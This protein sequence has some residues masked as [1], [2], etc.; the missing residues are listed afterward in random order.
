MSP[1]VIGNGSIETPERARSPAHSFGTLAVHT[2]S[3]HD[4]STG[5]VI[6]AVSSPDA[7]S[8]HSS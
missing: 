3:P 4:P 6:E 8:S 7:L 1:S 2:G 5:A